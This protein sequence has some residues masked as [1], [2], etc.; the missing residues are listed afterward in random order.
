LKVIADFGREDIA[1]VFIAE[2]E[3][4]RRVEFVESVQPPIPRKQ[5]WVS[6]VS[7]LYGCPVG[8]HFCDAGGS[9]TGKLTTEEILFQID[10]LVNNRFPDGS[11]QSDKWKIQF[12]RMGDPVLNP[13]VLDVLEL[14][15]GRYN[16]P[17]LTP[18]LSTITPKGCESFMTRL[19]EIKLRLYPKNFQ[20]Q[21]SLHT[22]DDAV[23]QRLIPVKTWGMSE[24]ADY[25]RSLHVKGGR[26]TALN[27]ALMN[28]V[29]IDAEILKWYF[30][31]EIFVLKVTPLNPTARAEAHGLTSLYDDKSLWNER[32]TDLRA[33]GFEVIE[34]V[35]E[36]AEN[37]IGSNCGQ[38]IT[39][40]N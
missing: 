1:T 34:S 37:A 27:F 7:T 11:V 2:N 31:P 18:S 39:R 5:K 14:L 30:D 22:T 26:K 35:G 29:P 21:F 19:R 13:N 20:F 40:L 32:I 36:M 15:P 33:V 25:G 28:D 3:A 23:R 38:Y 8:C 12:A 16:T 10:Y 4:G 9:Y 24:M 17:G 6:I